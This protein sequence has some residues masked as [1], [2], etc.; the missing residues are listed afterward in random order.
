MVELDI[1]SLSLSSERQSERKRWTHNGRESVYGFPVALPFYLS[2]V[3][4]S[5]STYLFLRLAISFRFF[6]CSTSYRR[7]KGL[8]DT[9]LV[10]SSLQL[11]QK[12]STEEI[13]QNSECHSTGNSTYNM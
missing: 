6:F 2:S 13:K 8:R 12:L 7:K 11:K 9:G 3:F 5:V 10:S 4:L 1:E